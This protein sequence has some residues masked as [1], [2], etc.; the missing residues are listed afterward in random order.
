MSAIE[1]MKVNEK[2][3]QNLLLISKKAGTSVSNEPY[4]ALTFQDHTGTIE[5][6]YWRST[7]EADAAAKVGEVVQVSGEVTSYKNMLQLKVTRLM[8]VDQ[9]SVDMAGFVRMSAVSEQTQKEQVQVILASLHNARIKTLVQ[10]MMDLVGEDFYTAP[11]A[12]TYHQN[13]KG[14]LAE[15]TLGIC[16]MAEAAAEEYPV[17]DRDLLVGGALIHDLGKTRELTSGLTLDMTEEGRLTGHI[18]IGHAMLVEV[19]QAKGLADS[20]E[21]LLLRHMMLAHHGHLEFGSPVLPA[22]PEAE[23]LSILDNL[24][25]RMSML[26]VSLK[27]VKPGEWS[28]KVNAMEG[29]MFYKRREAQ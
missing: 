26:A 2:I 24:D 25:A 6:R 14:G 8:N 20:E 17:L 22:I 11:A 19:A 9:S 10:G 21:A 1:D 5:G 4:L 16:R 3:C 13:W 18:S 23:A 27:S 12:K 29:R 15:H 28:A 7:P